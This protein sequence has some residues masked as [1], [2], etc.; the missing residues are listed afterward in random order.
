MTDFFDLRELRTALGRFATGVTVVTTLGTGGKT[1]GI[2]AN[3]FSSLSLEPPLILW[4]IGKTAPT[5]EIF[6]SCTHF[7]VNVLSAEQLTLS[8]HFAT[9]SEDKF[10]GVEWRSGISGIPLLKNVLACFECQS[11][12]Q[13]DGGDHTILVG[14]VESFTH[15]EGEPLLFSAGKYGNASDR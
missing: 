2:T 15:K 3:S 8:D 6:M 11:Y 4:C 14:K 7:A 5:H 1:E 13:H 12:D 9:S 10:I